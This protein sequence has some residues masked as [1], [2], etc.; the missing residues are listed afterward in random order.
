MPKIDFKGM[1]K[2]DFKGSGQGC[3]LKLDSNKN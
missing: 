2:I 1:P 3:D